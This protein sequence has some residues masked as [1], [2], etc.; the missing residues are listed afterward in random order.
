MSSPCDPG[1]LRAW[2]SNFLSFY[3]SV[4]AWLPSPRLYDSA[5]CFFRRPFLFFHLAPN[6]GLLS[7][8]FRGP[9][10]VTVFHS[11]SYCLAQCWFLLCFGLNFVCSFVFCFLS[12]H[13]HMSS[14]KLPVDCHYSSLALGVTVFGLLNI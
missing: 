10:C 1:F 6:L 3:S 14:C 5:K 9:P 7:W 11:H 2:I 12:S 8:M 4:L 13:S